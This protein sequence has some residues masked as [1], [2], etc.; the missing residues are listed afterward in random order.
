MREDCL[1][2]GGPSE[3][4]GGD[5]RLEEAR[6]MLG[7]LSEAEGVDALVPAEQ[8]ADVLEELLEG[9]EGERS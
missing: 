3:A 2:S 4:A 8:L 1:P 7:E 9:R 5:A 6:R